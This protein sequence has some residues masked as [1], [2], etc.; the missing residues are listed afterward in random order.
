M[1]TT[2]GKPGAVV[3]NSRQSATLSGGASVGLFKIMDITICRRQWADL[4]IS[5]LSLWWARSGLSTALFGGCGPT[6]ECRHGRF[7]GPIQ[8]Y[9][10]HYSM[11]TESPFKNIDISALVGP[12]RILGDIIKWSLRAHSI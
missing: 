10:R 1:G 11:V 8:D 7:G 6:R 9:R 3:N 4:G 12:F 5:T 2:A